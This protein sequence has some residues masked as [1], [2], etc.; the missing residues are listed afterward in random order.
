MGGPYWLSDSLAA[1]MLI[2]SGYCFA[3]LVVARAWG[4]SLHYDVNLAHVCMGVAMAGMLTASLHNLPNLWWE[5]VFGAFS[6]WFALRVVQFV[7]AYG[8]RGWD[9]DRL[10]HASHMSTHLLMALAMLYMFVALPSMVGG[11]GMGMASTPGAGAVLAYGFVVVLALS[12]VWHADGLSRFALANGTGAVE[13][14][15]EAGPGR[16]APANDGSLEAAD[17][18]CASRRW[19]AP[20]LETGCHIA[21]CVAMG[22]MLVLMR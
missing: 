19:L 11:G 21:M 16:G 1:V 15:V 18:A 7:R 14:P 17:V 8:A 3:R 13:V 4:R 9:E 22:Y 6:T 10:H 2:T 20:R 5:V 12:A